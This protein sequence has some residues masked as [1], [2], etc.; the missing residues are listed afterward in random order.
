MEDYYNSDRVSKIKEILPRFTKHCRVGDRIMWG[1]KGDPYWPKIYDENRPAGVIT[2]VKNVA[3]E[4]AT[5]RVRTDAGTV[6]DVPAYNVHPERVWEFEDTTFEK[7]LERSRA[8]DPSY[9]ASKVKSQ[10]DGLDDIR[11]KL[12]MLSARMDKE[13]HTSREF[14]GALI[15]SFNELAGEVHRSSG[16]P[17]STPFAANFTKEYRSMMQNPNAKE[18]KVFDSDFSDSDEDM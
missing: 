13:L 11:E 9:R 18:T 12:N 6:V 7:V 5:L 16:I 1:L 14:N 15:S 8:E 17:D 3:T 10:N 4:G 2:R